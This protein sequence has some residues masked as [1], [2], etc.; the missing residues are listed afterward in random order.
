MLPENLHWKLLGLADGRV[1]R[2]RFIS[3]QM[4]RITQPD[5]LNDPFE[6]QPRILLEEYSPEDREEA[7]KQAQEANFFSDS[8]PNDED[9]ERFF[10]APFPKGRY[11]E[12]RF[13]GLWPAKIPELRPESFQT[14]SELDEFKA[15]MIREDIQELLNNTFGVL[16]L[17]KDP[18]NLLMWSHY[19]A[20]HRGIAVGL[21]CAHHF[22]SDA[23]VLKDIDYLPKRVAISSNGGIIRIAGKQLKKETLPPI[24]TLLRKHPDWDYEE[25]LR[26]VV[27][28]AAADEP[29]RDDQGQMIY[30]KK[31]PHAAIKAI[32]LGARVDE[33]QRLDIIA[34]LR[35]EINMRHVRVFQA[36]LSD[37]EFALE[38]FEINVV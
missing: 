9:I 1:P 34:K 19:G 17:T 30:L 32:I 13:P 29:L 12:A 33:Q 27:P 20:E 36:K 7:R 31:I 8:E 10:L 18:S 2:S 6:M 3:D 15:R 4:F 28:L 24:Q 35:K 14:I 22:F 26:F 5:C 16:S 21:D 38:F 11:D 25:E 37:A 23:G